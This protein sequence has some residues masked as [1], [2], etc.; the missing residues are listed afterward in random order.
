MSRHPVLLGLVSLVGLTSCISTDEYMRLKGEKEALAAQHD[1]LLRYQKELQGRLQS[2]EEH[3]SALESTASEASAVRDLQ[4]R[5][6][7]TLEQLKAERGTNPVSLV[8]MEGVSIVERPDGVGFQVEGAVLFDPG[9]AVL[10]E[11]G[12]DTLKKLVAELVKTGRNVRVDGHTDNDPI[13]R[14]RWRTN[15]QLSAERASVV[16]EF[17]VSNGVPAE[18]LFVAGFGEHRP[19]DPGNTEDAKR[20][21]RR[22]EI[23]VMR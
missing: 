5:L 15:L 4:R 11:T 3:A 17:L 19:N 6:Q 22:V 13:A 2:I 21:N 8:P 14:S 1:D 10:K 18:R 23:L 7:Q 16:G 20:K 12:K 9:Q